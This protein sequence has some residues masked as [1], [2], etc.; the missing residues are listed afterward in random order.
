[1][2]WASQRRFKYLAILLAPPLLIFVV[3]L[4]LSMQTEPTCFDG[5]RNQDELGIDCGGVCQLLCPSQVSPIALLWH[6]SFPINSQYYNAV[7]FIE[8]PNF[9]AA[10]LEV[11]YVFILYDAEGVLVTERRGAAEIATDGIT[12]IFESRIHVGNRTPVRTE[13]RF[14]GPLRWHTLRSPKN[15]KVLTHETTNI[16]TEPRVTAT[17]RNEGLNELKDINV[18]AVVFDVDGNAL[19]A[20]QRLIEIFPGQSD[21]T[22]VFSW[23]Q[24]LNQEVGRVDIIPRI[25]PEAQL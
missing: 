7:A 11:P 25:P 2:S 19:L 1:M 8:N 18:V 6:R 9:D 10:V 3:W 22:I 15:V 20:S 5:E 24:P 16:D 13:F 21:E 14:E 23:P 17:L 12:P 4:V